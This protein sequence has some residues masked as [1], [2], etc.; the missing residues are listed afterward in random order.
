MREK[1]E[2]DE[3][4]QTTPGWITT[5][6]DTMSLLLCFFVML[7]AA[8]SLNEV[9]VKQGLGSLKG[10]LGGIVEGVKKESIIP[11]KGT[12]ERLREEMEEY[13][14]S[15]GLDKEVKINALSEGISISLSSPVLF[16]SGKAKLRKEVFPLLNK[17][18]TLLKEIPNQIRVEGH[19]DNLPIH[20]EEFP[21]NW[22]LSTA[23]A[24]SV[25]K[26]LIKEKISPERIGVI[27]YAD[28]RPLFPNDTPE[29]RASN[30]RVEIFILK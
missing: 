30:R 20:T 3:S 27:G 2:R 18:V 26:Y 29:H 7:Y 4:G 12:I 11:Q 17:I 22:E 21:S 16:D 28:S 9:R 23:R 24:I 8:T 14:V 6:G 1:K 25:G 13:V 19:T 10:A 5:F 15:E